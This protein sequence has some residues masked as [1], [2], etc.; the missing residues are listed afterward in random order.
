ME[1]EDLVVSCP[2][3]GFE[4]ID[5]DGFGFTY[6]EHCY[7]CAHVSLDGLGPGRWRCLTCGRELDD[8]HREVGRG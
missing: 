3:C 5:L 6:C 8:R 2:R 7:H 1:N 4:M